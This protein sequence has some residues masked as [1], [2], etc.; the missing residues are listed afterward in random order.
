VAVPDDVHMGVDPDSTLDLTRAYHFTTLPNLAY[1]ASSGFP[2]TH[3]A[4]LSES[5]AVLPE[6]PSNV[7]LSAFLNLMAHI[8]AQTFYP[9][10]RLTVVR[11]ADI[12]TVRN[13]HLMVLGTLS[14]LSGAAELLSES[15][16]RM[17]PDRL[18][19]LLPTP[20]A[21]IW[22][23]FGDIT[24]QERRRAAAALTTTLADDA[25]AMIG[26]RSPLDPRRS[27]V[28][29]LAGS[30]QGVE[31]MVNALSNPKLTPDIRGDL[32]L[33]SG[34]QVTSFR[35]GNVYTMGYLPFWLW[36]ERW[37]RDEPQW[38]LALAV[39][40]SAMIGMALYRVLRW[41][42]GR[43]VFRPRQTT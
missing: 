35:A 33:L 36:P 28:A 41:R 6:R 43:R 14:H 23:L 42:R 31:T 26:A 9:V 19:V 20:L 8:G 4:D 1:F 37:L 34:G 7:E 2:F 12:A 17:G 11:P 29:V 30:P 16:Y 25:G 22:R 10:I 3:M 21:D 38:V 13:K 39:V 18:S 5:A 27:L 15:P 24:S 40:A 32:V